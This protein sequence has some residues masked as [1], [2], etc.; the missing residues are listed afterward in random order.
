LIVSEHHGS[1]LGVWAIE[2]HLGAE[3]FGAKFEEILVVTPE[4]A[5]WLDDQ[6]PHA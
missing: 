3:G 1:K 4:G 6:V 5:R 2:P